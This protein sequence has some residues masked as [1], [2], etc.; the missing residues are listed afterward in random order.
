MRVTRAIRERASEMYGELLERKLEVV[1][2]PAPDPRHTCHY[3]RVAQNT[4]PR[5]FSELARRHMRSSK[6][7]PKPRPN[8]IKREATLRALVAIAAGKVTTTYAQRWYAEIERHLANE[9]DAERIPF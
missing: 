1:L 6:R 4:P 8:Y 2:I 3:I 7:C 5:W 9:R